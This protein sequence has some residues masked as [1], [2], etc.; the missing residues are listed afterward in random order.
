M[1]NTGP[2][3]HSSSNLPESDIQEWIRGFKSAGE[4]CLSLDPPQ[5][6]SFPDETLVGE[7]GRLGLQYFAAETLALKKEE[8][9]DFKWLFDILTITL[10]GKIPLL[11]WYLQY[12]DSLKIRAERCL[13]V[14]G[15]QNLNVS[16]KLKYLKTSFKNK[17]VTDIQAF[18]NKLKG[19]LAT[20]AASHNH[21]QAL[22][23]DFNPL[24]NQD[25]NSEGNSK[26]RK[27]EALSSAPERADEEKQQLFSALFKFLDDPNKRDYFA[28]NA[29]ERFSHHS[30]TNGRESVY[31]R[32][33]NLAQEHQGLIQKS[34][35]NFQDKLDDSKCEKL[36]TL[37]E[38]HVE[39][40]KVKYHSKY[41][42]LQ[43][44]V[45]KIYI[46][47]TP[48][49]DWYFQ[50]LKAV[51]N[52]AHFI[53]R[54]I[55]LRFKADIDQ[56]NLIVSILQKLPNDKIDVSPLFKLLSQKLSEQ[57]KSRRTDRQKKVLSN[58]QT[59]LA[60]TN[61]P[62]A[63]PGVNTDK[64]EVTPPH[65]RNEEAY[66]HFIL[67]LEAF[68]VAYLD[69]LELKVHQGG[70][71]DAFEPSKRPKLSSAPESA[72]REKQELF[73][74]KLF[75][76]L[77]NP[78]IPN[79]FNLNP[80]ANV[81]REGRK[82]I[83]TALEDLAKENQDLNQNGLLNYS[84][85]IDDRIKS[86]IERL[87]DILF[88]IQSARNV[89]DY[90]A[91]KTLLYALQLNRTPILVWHL[92]NLKETKAQADFILRMIDSRDFI[93]DDIKE[94]IAKALKVF[95]NDKNYVLNLFKILHQEI[96]L[97][98]R[99]EKT[100]AKGRN[101]F[102]ELLIT[103][104]WGE[105]L[106]LLQPTPSRHDLSTPST[107][108]IH[109]LKN[110][111][112]KLE[113]GENTEDTLFDIILIDNSNTID[114]PDDSSLPLGNETKNKLFN[115]LLK[116]RTEYH[117][118]IKINRIL[119]EKSDYI[120]QIWPELSHIEQST[121]LVSALI[122]K[123]MGIIDKFFDIDIYFKILEEK[124]ELHK[125]L[126]LYLMNPL[127]IFLKYLGNDLE[128]RKKVHSFSK[129]LIKKTLFGTTVLDLYLSHLNE[130]DVLTCLNM[131]FL[132]NAP[133]IHTFLHSFEWKVN[134]NTMNASIYY[135]T[136]VD[137]KSMF[138][139]SKNLTDELQLRFYRFICRGY[140]GQKEDGSQFQAAFKTKEKEIIREAI[141]FW[142]AKY[143]NLHILK[144]IKDF[145]DF[146]IRLKGIRTSGQQPTS[147]FFKPSNSSHFS[148]SSDEQLD[149]SIETDP[150]ERTVLNAIE[151]EGDDKFIQMPG[152][153]NFENPDFVSDFGMFFGSGSGN[154][155]FTQPPDESIIH[156]ETPY[157]QD[158][159]YVPFSPGPQKT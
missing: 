14:L 115:Q 13:Q 126:F 96:T 83:Y 131:L 75:K 156:E 155:E 151:D 42:C 153:F 102:R 134:S 143:P 150:G 20:Q 91:S 66:T 41:S 29:K 23:D 112:K 58:I 87:I 154:S 19:T 77:E 147:T 30:I 44:L 40:Q 103:F 139:P 51:E 121:I 37:V 114:K 16:D 57:K 49:L 140:F 141:C 94:I 149:Y 92:Q 70:N 111:P 88:H 59:K 157:I 71:T 81:A 144:K 45:D 108:E 116:A 85:E 117:G 56:E 9:Q 21:L 28:L 18:L 39:S 76:L 124:K 146:E 123:N 130:E 97:S 60:N 148:T 84:G 110:H 53:M 31:L 142:E 122:A 22:L 48:L 159:F 79:W 78:S 35:L 120:D 138:C 68:A 52:Q 1:Q 100:I 135:L 6:C 133:L 11:V 89:K 25:L 43:N 46:H 2:S 7:V 72:N 145:L 54:I 64:T 73:F 158:T 98:T 82:A 136:Y 32:L 95:Q 61:L 152:A 119:Q 107:S 93:I 12:P 105:N 15:C 125:D 38:I 55:S 63:N 129:N 99:G 47:D 113:K 10:V 127:I 128:H 5:G 4:Y 104:G 33:E 106:E 50:G 74:F 24:H 101:I 86:K 80:T 90:P 65:A 62:I 26:K 36:K 8:F 34:H 67:C 132:I 137:D 69:A 109:A 27:H 17:R 118:S 3:V